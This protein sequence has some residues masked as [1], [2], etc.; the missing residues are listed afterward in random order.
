MLNGSPSGGLTLLK[1]TKNKLQRFHIHKTKAQ[2][3]SNVFLVYL[4]YKISFFPEHTSHAPASV[5]ALLVP[6]PRV[7]STTASESYS[8]APM[9]PFNHPLPYP[10]FL[11]FIA[12]FT[13]LYTIIRVLIYLI[14]LACTFI[15]LFLFF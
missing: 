13:T 2:N 6:L 7:I 11:F 12:P 9:P 14:P 5:F 10:T 3:L 1:I 15:F 4:G 8:C